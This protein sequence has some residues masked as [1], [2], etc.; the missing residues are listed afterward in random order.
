LRFEWAARLEEAII[1]L[2]GAITGLLDRDNQ[3]R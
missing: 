2:V 1:I 3:R